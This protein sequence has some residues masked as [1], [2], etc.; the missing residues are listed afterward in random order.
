MIIKINMRGNK[1]S[2][3]L[4]AARKGAGAF[5]NSDNMLIRG[6][7]LLKRPLVKRF[8]RQNTVQSNK[9][10]GRVSFT[11]REDNDEPEG[12]EKKAAEDKSGGDQNNNGNK[13]PYLRLRGF[14]EAG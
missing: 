7:G 2:G 13:R 4:A 14:P 11:D 9:K 5:R 1:D 10:G 8:R 12:V 3:I 6:E